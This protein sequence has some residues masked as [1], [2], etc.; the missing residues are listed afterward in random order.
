M[1]KIKDVLR[2]YFELSLAQRQIAE[3]VSLGQATVSDYLHRFERAQLTWPVTLT[4][5]ELEAKLFPASIHRVPTA[6]PAQ[7][8]RPMPDF[9]VIDN[10]LRTNKHVTLQLLWE[11]Y[12]KDNLAGHYSYSR[13]CHHYE[14][15]KSRRDVTMRQDHPAGE[16][17]FVDWA[18]AKIPIHDPKTGEVRQASIFVAVLGASN[19]TYVEATP[20]E[21]IGDWIGAHVRMFEFFGGAS[22]LLIPDN[23]KTGVHK[24]CRYE[25]DLNPLYEAMAEHYGAGVMPARVRKPRDKAKVEVGVQVAQR[26]I[27]AAL[28]HHRFH[29]VGAVNEAIAELLT[30]LNERPFRK[31]EGSRR[32]WFEKLDRPALRPLPAERFALEAWKKA[33]VNI[34]YHIEFERCLYSVPYHLTRQAVDVRV[35][36]S[37]VEI[38]HRGERVAS[39]VRL[40]GSNQRSTHAEHQPKSH[41]AH[42]EWPPS[43]IIDWAG[44][45]GPFTA[46][47]VE[48]ILLDKPHPEM[49]YRACL[50]IIRLGDKYT[51]P[52]VEAAAERALLCGAISYKSVASM[53]QRG[54]DK[55]AV[56][57]P[58]TPSS[59]P[60]G[61][62][63]NIRGS[64]YFA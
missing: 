59:A 7:P 8:K 63:G 48:R 33:T 14:V 3:S 13:F 57:S 32:G 56:D 43:R 44:G 11:E 25:P 5:E 39:H 27:V 28:R 54:I 46:Q 26:W 50:G 6:A 17:I 47:L 2:L 64:E 23:L 61:H 51:K 30:W 18:G 55:R 9:A 12:S 38:F 29:S 34:D 40:T 21:T 60:A 31:L 15:W 22:A 52:R 10:E 24:P 42:N 45:V 49:G 36:S 58:E 35:T 62:H 1:R 41:R 53:L 16:R 4:E 37:T 19:Y 20:G